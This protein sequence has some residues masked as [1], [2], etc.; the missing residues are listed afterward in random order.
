MVDVG[1]GVREGGGLADRA[2]V[3]VLTRMFPVELVDRV[4]DQYWRREQRTR[5]LPA[6]LVFYF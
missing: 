4:I 5:A 3:G 1:L 2:A 6:R